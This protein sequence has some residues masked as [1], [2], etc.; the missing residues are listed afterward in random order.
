[1]L[2]KAVCDHEHHQIIEKY[3]LKFQSQ[4]LE[5]FFSQEKNFYL[6]QHRSPVTILFKTHEKNFKNKNKHNFQKLFL[7]KLK[8]Y[9]SHFFTVHIDLYMRLK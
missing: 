1:M 6:L 7:I 2:F 8:L 5:I 9:I 3:V 4:L